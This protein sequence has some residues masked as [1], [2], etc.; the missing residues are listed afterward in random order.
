ME[1]NGGESVL[2]SNEE[3]IMAYGIGGM[4]GIRAHV[5]HDTYKQNQKFPCLLV[6]MF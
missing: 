6:V 4:E 2:F 3:L 1:N 5:A